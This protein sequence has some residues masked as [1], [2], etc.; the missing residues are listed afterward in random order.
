MSK[1]KKRKHYNCCLC[2]FY[3]VELS[4]LQCQE[5]YQIYWKS[6]LLSN[7]LQKLSEKMHGT[8]SH[9]NI[10]QVHTKNSDTIFAHS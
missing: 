3:L 4:V 2:L 8:S 9:F 1:E 5:K 10:L 7:H 6:L